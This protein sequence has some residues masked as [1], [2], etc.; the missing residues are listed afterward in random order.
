MV[1]ALS[2]FV[3]HI[4]TEIIYRLAKQKCSGCRKRELEACWLNVYRTF[5]ICEECDKGL[6]RFFEGGQIIVVQANELPP[7]DFAG[8][9]PCGSILCKYAFT[10][11][12]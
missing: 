12:G 2:K 6:D 5:R 11:E 9:F 3:S 4:G 7:K 8:V 10:Q 1:E